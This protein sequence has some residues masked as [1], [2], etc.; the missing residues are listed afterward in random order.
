M[1]S[2]EFG[3]PD[4][5]FATQTNLDH[6]HLVQFNRHLFSFVIAL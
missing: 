6:Q 5:D 3:D 4:E 1:S 2:Y